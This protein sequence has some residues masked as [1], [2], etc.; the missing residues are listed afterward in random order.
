MAILPTVFRAKKPAMSQPAV[1]VDGL[2][3]VNPMPSKVVY[4]PIHGYMTMTADALMLIDTPEYQRLRDL[5]QLGASYWTFPG[6]SHNRFEHCL[7]V[8]HL[9]VKWAERFQRNQPELEIDGRDIQLVRLAGLCHDL[10]HGPLSHCWEG[11]MRS[12]LGGDHRW[13][14]EDM[15]LKMLELMFERYQLWEPMEMESS[16]LRVIC[17]LISGKPIG[18]M[19]REKRFLYDIVANGRN[20]IDVDK[21]DY[22]QRD[23]FNLGMKMSYDSSR[24][25][26]YSKVI[27]NEICFYSKEAFNVYQ[28]YHTRFVMHKE[29][30][31]HPV[32]KAIELMMNDAIILAD[33]YMG[34]KEKCETAEEFWPLT[35]CVIRDI[36]FSRAED[37]GMQAARDLIRRIRR[38][39]LYKFVD[40]IVL[41][42]EQYA[43]YMPIREAD[44]VHCQSTSEEVNLNVDDIIVDVYHLN[45]SRKDK[46]PVDSVHF[47]AHFDDN[48]SMSIPREKVSHLIP[49]AFEEHY[50]RIFCRE[51]SR[52]YVKAAKDAFRTWCRKKNIPSP[53][54]S[55]VRFAPA[56]SQDASIR[57]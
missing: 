21:F 10:G 17:S 38:R 44:I 53:M 22:L 25:I 42:P 32:G 51:S 19:K 8:S 15:S 3:S 27:D 9:S 40:E 31:S 48:E 6:G 29:V 11:V 41:T 5:K 55:F 34:F 26:Q 14:H 7:G 54:R 12:L 28:L 18:E 13:S 24:L 56:Y 47:Y 2:A 49:T 23:C 57:L 4:D 43:Q 45:Y 33:S 35:D 37:R 16:D 20:G 50:V 39:E 36:E 46:N 1:A 30:Y 52:D